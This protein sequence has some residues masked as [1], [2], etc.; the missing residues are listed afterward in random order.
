MS[1]TVP[2]GASVYY[3]TDGSTPVYVG[4]AKSPLYEGPFVINSTCVVKAVAYKTGETANFSLQ[5]SYI[6]TSPSP[7]PTPTPTPTPSQAAPAPIS[8]VSRKI[9]NLAG[10]FDIDLMPPAPGIECRSGGASSDHTLVVTFPVPVTVNGN[11]AVEARVTSGM[12]EV[13]AGFRYRRWQRYRCQRHRG[14]GCFS[15][16]LQTLR[17]LTL[18][19]LV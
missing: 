12:A 3:T 19:S 15:Q 9:H 16:T 11:G 7:T 14:D 10:A 5:E 4:T 2:S 13:G 18:P 8:V 17:D 6:I 1:I